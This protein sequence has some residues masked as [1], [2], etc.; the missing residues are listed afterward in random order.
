MLEFEHWFRT[1]EACRDYL[2]GLRWP[3]GFRCPGCEGSQHW[4]KSRGLLRCGRCRRDTSVMAGTIFSRSHLPLRVW[5]RAAWW[6]TNQKS[7]VT[8]IGLQ[9]ALGLGSYRTAWGCLHKLR[10]AMLRP[11]RDQLQDIVEVDETIVGGR[12][13]GQGRLHLGP[14]KSL[15]GIAVEVRGKGSGRVRLQ[16]IANTSGESL[17]RFVRQ[18]VAPGSKVRTDGRWGYTGLAR[19]GYR[20]DPVVLSG[21]GDQASTVFLPRVHRVSSLLKRWLLGVH[22]G[23]ISKRH[24]DYYL[25]E[26]SFRFNRRSSPHRGQL[27]YRLLLQAVAIKHT[28]IHLLS[29]APK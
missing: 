23:G 10:R 1:E 17:E 7:G 9:R 2:I 24:L 6:A 21:K 26:F 12:Q 11:G 5:F 28:P 3:G 15:V 13:R 18:S 4:P 25:D 27:C 22:H 19:F 20:H 8:A 16:R 14:T 29:E